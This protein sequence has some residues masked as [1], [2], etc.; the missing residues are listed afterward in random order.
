MPETTV[1]ILAE[2]AELNPEVTHFMLRQYH[3][4]LG[5]FRDPKDTFSYEWISVASLH[6][7]RERIARCDAAGHSI[8]VAN[9]VMTDKGLRYLLMLD[10]SIPISPSA[11]AELADKLSLFMAS[12]D[13]PYRMDGY[14]LQTNSSYHYLGT[15][16]TTQEQFVNFLGSALLFRHA[17]NSGFVVDDR[18]LGHSLKK[19]FGTVRIGNKAGRVPVVVRA[20]RQSA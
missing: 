2:I 3:H 12:G 10:Y 4:A 7:V 11:E 8:G 13:A 1:D 9:M 16:V 14:L 5:S 19:G 17:E 18:W 15:Y 20:V 6:L